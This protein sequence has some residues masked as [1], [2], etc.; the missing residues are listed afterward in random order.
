M[1]CLKILRLPIIVLLASIAPAAAHVVLEKPAAVLGAPYKGVLKV[2]H[3]CKGAATIRIKVQI[4]EGVIA[5]K[6]MPKPGWSVET[7]RAAYA[8]AYAFY[9][10][11]T[12]SEG[13][14]EI[15]W[16]GGPLADEHYDEFVF[17]GFVAKELPPDTTL[18]FP[19]EQT[20]TTGAHH[21]AEIPAAGQDPHSLEQPAAALHVTAP[22]TGKP[23]H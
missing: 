1:R 21:W 17:A 9:H 11:M 13:V 14:R 23:H 2:T 18:Y 19:V 22:A 4:P 15:T 16:S 12:M 20:C 7:G 3:G 5:V 8:R 10:G 6:P